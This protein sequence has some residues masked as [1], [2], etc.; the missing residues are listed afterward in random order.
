MT[1]SATPATKTN[2][3]RFEDLPCNLCG[4]N[5]YDVVYH[6]T[7]P[8]KRHVTSDNYSAASY[9]ILEDQVVKCKKCGFMYI[10]PRP[11]SEMIV[12]GYSAA[13]DEAYV[14]QSE[15]RIATF[16]GSLKKIEKI[17]P[18]KGRILDVGC[19]AGFFLKAAKDEGWD[20]YG[21]EPSR[22][23]ADW[24]NKNFGLNIR[25]GTLEGAKFPD[26]YFDVV[27]LWDVLEHVPDAAGTLK[28]INR[29][30][31]PGGIVVVNYPNMGSN[32]AKVFGRKWWFLLSVHLYYFTPKTIKAMLEKEGFELALHKHHYQKLKLGY[33]VFRVQPYSKLIFRALNPIVQKLGLADRNVTY[34]ASQ[35]L[36][37]GRKVK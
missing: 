9:H 14:S 26:K 19:A 18:Q 16:K 6:A 30:L 2:D 35:S 27:T 29:I 3:P 10:N 23:L 37:I 28:E 22:W 11:K 7:P 36:A 13:V 24:G 34:Y 20:T 4:A 1:A 12:E 25:A 21:V 17:Y 15:G 5:D 8:E 31:K 32:L 33:L